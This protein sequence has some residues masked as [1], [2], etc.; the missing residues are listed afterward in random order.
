[1]SPSFSTFGDPEYQKKAMFL[2]R[3]VSIP[4]IAD[5][6]GFFTQSTRGLRALDW[7]RKRRW[8]SGATVRGAGRAARNESRAHVCYLLVCGL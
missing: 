6:D 1:M 5:V 7:R 3:T 4:D 8:G 2:L